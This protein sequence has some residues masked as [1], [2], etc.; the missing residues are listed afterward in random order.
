MRRMI[1]DYP[2]YKWHWCWMTTSKV[3]HSP[4]SSQ[5]CML[6]AISSLNRMANDDGNWRTLSTRWNYLVLFRM[7]TLSL[8]SL[9]QTM[10]LLKPKWCW[11]S[12]DCCYLSSLDWKCLDLSMHL[13]P[14]VLEPFQRSALEYFGNSVV[15]RHLQMA[16]EKRVSW[17]YFISIILKSRFFL[18]LCSQRQHT[19]AQL[20]TGHKRKLEVSHKRAP[21]VEANK[22]IKIINNGNIFNGFTRQLFSQESHV[23][24]HKY[25]R[26][27]FTFGFAQ[28]KPRELDVYGVGENTEKKELNKNGMFH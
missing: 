19:F 27:D 25:P 2:T 18:L 11:V 17:K 24:T 3:R 4:A 14:T 5:R 20:I 8:R 21:E 6:S 7:M 26:N 16:T 13:R 23:T 12:W 9:E 10:R 22:W 28:A 15:R 1:V